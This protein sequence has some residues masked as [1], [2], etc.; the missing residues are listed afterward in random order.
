MV[1]INTP[2][3]GSVYARWI[4]LASVRAFRPDDATLLELAAERD[5]N[6]RIT[7]VYSRWDPHI[8][9]GSVLAGAANVELATPGHF[10]A[11]ADPRLEQVLLAAVRGD[12]GQPEAP[13]GPGGPAAA[14][15]GGE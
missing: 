12:A 10:R 8:P 15:A 9:G 1:A 13:P 4:P 2:F 3:A 7:S 5:V 6:A 14:A 11:L